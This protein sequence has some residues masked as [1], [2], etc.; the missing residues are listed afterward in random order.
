MRLAPTVLEQLQVVDAVAAGCGVSTATSMPS[1][2]GIVAGA[3]VHVQHLTLPLREGGSCDNSPGTSPGEPPAPSVTLPP[4]DPSVV[5]KC[6]FCSKMFKFKSELVRHL[7]THTGEK[8]YACR[9][10]PHRCARLYNMK[11]HY[12]HKHK[13]KEPLE[14]ILRYHQQQ[15][16][17]VQQPQMEDQQSAVQQS[18]MDDQLPQVPLQQ[19]QMDDQQ[20]S[21]VQQPQMDDQLQSLDE[22]PD[23]NAEQDQKPD[24]D[25]FDQETSLYS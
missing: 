12:E 13:L 20:L 21:A 17:A 9:F 23:Q 4:T 6:R 8:P 2:A 5:F 10:C 24:A 7:R 16:G 11:M 22:Q 1:A 18:E 15:Q 19:P 14:E 25:T 3:Q